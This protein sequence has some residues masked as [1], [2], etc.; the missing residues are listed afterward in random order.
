M[1]MLLRH[2][3]NNANLQ[4]SCDSSLRPLFRRFAE[5]LPLPRALLC[6]SR[7]SRFLNTFASN[8]LPIPTSGQVYKSPI[9]FVIAAD[10]SKP[11]IPDRTWIFRPFLLWPWNVGKPSFRKLFP[12]LPHN[13][14]LV[15]VLPVVGVHQ[16]VEA[17]RLQG[18]KIWL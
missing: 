13:C 1:H 5:L 18:K 16:L 8:I 12:S 17:L 14:R 3:Y 4:N 6:E 10:P 15:V 7:V 2:I 9:I 11:I